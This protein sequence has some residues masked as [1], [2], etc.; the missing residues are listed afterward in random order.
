M[1]R[2]Q[3]KR[4]CHVLADRVGWEITTTGKKWTVE[5]PETFAGLAFMPIALLGTL[6]RVVTSSAKYSGL[7]VTRNEVREWFDDR[8]LTPLDL[9]A[10]T[11]ATDE[12]TLLQIWPELG[13]AGRRR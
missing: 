12:V 8:R 4:A 11:S 13:E 6:L 9:P 2:S 10:A 3:I 7:G 5:G 1:K